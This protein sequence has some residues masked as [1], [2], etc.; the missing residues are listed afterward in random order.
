MDLACRVLRRMADEFRELRVEAV[1][2]VATSAVRDATNQ[3]EFVARASAVMG[4]PLEVITGMEEARLVQLGVEDSWPHPTGRTLIVDVGGGSVQ[5]IFGEKGHFAEAFSKPLGAVRLTEAFLKSDP[6]TAAEMTRMRHHIREELAGAT[7][8]L[9]RAR[10][11]RLI[12]TSS[13][14]AAVVCAVNDVR[15]SRR[16]DADRMP[17]T[18]RQVATLLDRLGSV[19]LQGRSQITGIGPRRAEIVIAG[20]AVLHEVLVRSR[21]PRFHYSTAGVRDGLIA[22]LMR[23]QRAGRRPEPDAPFETRR[24]SK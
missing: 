13:T 21:L 7:R 8:R 14:A 20:T 12:A 22:E 17:A 15:R 16:D 23:G 11:Q 9:Q 2:A 18:T 10:P 6:P 19:D 3:V 24:G 1:R 5:V 4:V